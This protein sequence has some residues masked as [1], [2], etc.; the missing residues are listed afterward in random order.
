[1]NSK[2]LP[3][4]SASTA[5]TDFERRFDIAEVYFAILRKFAMVEAPKYFKLGFKYNLR[6]AG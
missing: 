3:E 5:A 2:N 1:V 6:S 4:P